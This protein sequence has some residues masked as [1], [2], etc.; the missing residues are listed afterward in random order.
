ETEEERQQGN[1]THHDATDPGRPGK[2]L[3]QRRPRARDHDPEG[4][5]QENDREIIEE[6]ANNFAAVVL[7][8]TFRF[9]ELLFMASTDETDA[10]IDE[11]QHHQGNAGDAAITI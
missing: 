5:E 6:R 11:E 1:A 2:L 7:I 3:V 10:D 9:G 4:H 8:D